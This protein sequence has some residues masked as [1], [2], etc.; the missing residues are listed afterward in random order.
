MAEG[1]EGE[2]TMIL[3]RPETPSGERNRPVS[4]F[5]EKRELQAATLATLSD[6]LSGEANLYFQVQDQSWGDG[7]F[8]DLQ[9]Q[10]ISPRSIVRAVDM[11]VSIFK[12]LC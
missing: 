9:E 10:A 3:V 6:L 1:E 7:V 4:F 12:L 11:K 5:G 8:V 2:K